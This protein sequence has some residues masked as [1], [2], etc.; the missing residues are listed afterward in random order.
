MEKLRLEHISK[1]EFLRVCG[2]CYKAKKQS[3]GYGV[4]RVIVADAAAAPAPKAEELAYKPAPASTV[5]Q[6]P[7][8]PPKPTATID[9]GGASSRSEE[10]RVGKEC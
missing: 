8:P 4:H 5:N 9:N 10:R 7:A 2:V 1:D 3:I 6:Q